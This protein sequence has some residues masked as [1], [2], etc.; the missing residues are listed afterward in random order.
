MLCVLL[1]MQNMLG[2]VVLPKYASHKPMHRVSRQ[3]LLLLFINDTQN[4][5]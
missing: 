4:V 5:Q 2:N 1:H 3:A